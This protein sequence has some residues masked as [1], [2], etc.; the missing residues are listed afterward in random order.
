MTM[1]AKILPLV[2]LYRPG[3]DGAGKRPWFVFLE[4]AG[5]ESAYIY[6]ASGKT[7]Q[8]FATYEAAAEDARKRNVARLDDA[9]KE[10]TAARDALIV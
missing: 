2:P 10:L 3:V 7:I 4:N 6:T 5:T 8:G 1:T 9:I